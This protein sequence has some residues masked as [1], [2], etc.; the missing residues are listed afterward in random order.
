MAETEI[1]IGRAGETPHRFNLSDIKNGAV[2]DSGEFPELFERQLPPMVSGALIS[3]VERKLEEHRL[4]L[5]PFDFPVYLPPSLLPR[6]LE[7]SKEEQTD[8]VDITKGKLQRGFL[9]PVFSYAAS[10]EDVEQQQFLDD[11]ARRAES[12]SMHHLIT[13]ADDRALRMD[14]VFLDP[15]YGHL[16]DHSNDQ[17]REIFEK[18]HHTPGKRVKETDGANLGIANSVYRFHQVKESLRKAGKDFDE[19]QY[20]DTTLCF[21][22]MLSGHIAIPEQGLVVTAVGNPRALREINSYDMQQI[23]K[24]RIL[25]Y[26]HFDKPVGEDFPDWVTIHALKRSLANDQT[27][28]ERTGYAGIDPDM[29]RRYLTERHSPGAAMTAFAHMLE[30][31]KKGKDASLRPHFVRT[32]KTQNCFNNRKFLRSWP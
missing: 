32:H 8:Q 10:L 3:G 15:L 12:D 25:T 28:A 4:A 17:V 18:G 13:F 20:M 29:A 24:G 9:G 5:E 23:A 7:D 26:D 31:P 21:V 22:P 11:I 30:I 27:P 14:P 1:L 16:R 6:A 2:R 19:Y